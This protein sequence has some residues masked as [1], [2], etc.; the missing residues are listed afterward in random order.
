MKKCLV[1]VAFVV[2]YVFLVNC[3]LAHAQAVGAITGTVTDPSGA[4]IPGVKVTATR[5]ETGIS[6]STVTS[7]AGTYTIPN[8]VVGTYNVTAEAQGFKSGRAEGI[9]L[10][11]SQQR[12]VDFTLS[13]AGVV[14]TVQVNAAP[15][16]LNTTDATVAGLV[17][18]DQV[19]TL[20]LNGRSIG[21]LVLM[22]SGMAQ[23]N[24]GGMGWLSPMWISNGNRGETAV[25]TLDNADSTDRLMGNIQFWNF[26]LDGIAEFKVVQSNY[27]AE[28]GQ[29]AGTITQIVSKSGTNGFHGSAFEFV[30]NNDLDA[31]NYFATTAQPLQRNEFGFTFGGPIKK[32]KTFFF[33]E[34]AGFRQRS[35]EPVLIPVPTATE[36]QGQ[37]TIADP[38]TGQPDQLQVPLN[39]VAQ[40]VLS[41]YPSPNQP[42]GAFGANTYNF[43]FK[44]PTTTNQFSV[45]LD[46]HF[47]EKDSFFARASYVNNSELDI[48]PV[49]AS[50]GAGFSDGEY[51]NPRNYSL[52]ETHIFT[53]TLLNLLSFTI[54]RQNEGEAV[55]NQTYAQTT[56]AD[57]SLGNWGPDTFECDLITTYY[58]IPDNVTWTKGRHTFNFGAKYE[59]GQM[60]GEGVTS[61]GPNGAYTFDAGTALLEAVP[62]TNGG[63]SLGVGSP[64]PSG[65]VSM[66]EG[67]D[68]SYGRSLALPGYGPAGGG[69]GWWGVRI[70]DFAT[71]VQD[72]IKVTPKL[73]VNAGL[74]YEYFSVPYE[75]DNRFGAPADQGS[76]YGR[77]VLNPQPLYQPD[78]RNFAPRFGVAYRVTGK[79]VLR[80][81]LG[82]FTNP[83]TGVYPTQ[84]S[85]D[86]PLASLGYVLSATY[87]LTPLPVT[88]PPMT[89]VNG[90]TVM[91]PQGNTKLIPANTPVNLLADANAS[92]LIVGDWA[93]DRMRN[94]YAISGNATVEHE[95]PGGVA[96]SA[97]YVA[98]NGVHLWN[99]AYPNA[100]DGADPQY[101]P[102]SNITPGLGELML[103]YNGAYSSYN[104]LQVQAR[105][106]APSH[107]L[108][109]QANYT[110]AKDM[111]DADSVFSSSGT[112]GA[113]TLNNP[114]CLK[115]ERAP[116]SYNVAQR[117]VA[118]FSYELPFGRAQSLP[119]RLTN[120]WQILGISTVQSGFPF[121]IVGPYGTLPYG[122]DSFNF[123]GARPFLLQRPTKNPAGGQQFFS[124]AVIAGTTPGVNDGS[125]GNFFTIPTT[126]SPYFGGATVE[127]VPG[128]LGRNTNIGPG[129]WNFDFSVIKDTRITESK[130]LQFRAE[131]FNVLNHP[132]FATP[133]GTIGNG[134]FGTSIATQTLERQLQFGLRF[135]F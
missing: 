63:T 97:A 45:R 82:I 66:M 103:F 111:T 67:D 94:A 37:V 44:Q 10:D 61:I 16:T 38:V 104:S 88:I 41:K 53:P 76:L 14:S 24:N 83:I 25:A 123:V 2:T 70:W 1:S 69:A 42:L 102:Y 110:Y 56:F 96:L 33:G 5:A 130:M 12:T 49:A 116:A 89:T 134:S 15:P 64:S 22:Q 98:N 43:V 6:Q 107:G 65:M 118:N 125:N 51:N 50:E 100:Y 36:R 106:I 58:V 74:R 129:W 84:D 18:G 115:C 92:G 13:L 71:Y 101:T 55:P 23:D 108:V 57:G 117:F 114:H 133:I 87:S 9:S 86:T 72:D 131:F 127:T 81:G 62:S 8:L 122:F 80:G 48:D 52:S 47:S 59:R 26:N 68:V 79:T 17:S 35:G 135:I 99:Q 46:Q 77:F 34:Y 93:S 28:Y 85:G 78:Y 11:V 132:T 21:N 120:G 124:N 3:G 73:T 109:F 4:V 128:N 32:D 20:P 30:R 113:I 95:F 126:T 7:G 54:N 90:N 29:G 91:P 27:S 119:K 31:L 75:V 19:Q 105:K 39:A 112:S 40:S 121:T 60:N